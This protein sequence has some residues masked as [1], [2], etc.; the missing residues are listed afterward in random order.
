[1]GSFMKIR[2]GLNVLSNF[3]KPRAEL[4]R[5]DVTLENRGFVKEVLETNYGSPDPLSKCYSPLKVAP[6]EPSPEWVRGSRRT[7]TIARKLGIYPM[8]LKNGKKVLSTLLH[9]CDN[10]VIKYIPPEEWEPGHR[11][12][13]IIPK[14]KLGCL[15]VGAESSDPQLFTKEYCGLFY[16][17]G[18]MPKRLLSRFAVTPN[19][20]LQPGTPLLATHYRPG[21]VIDIRGKTIDRGF[22]GVM[23]RWG[24]HGMPA[25]HGVTKTHRR[26]GNIGSGGQKARVMPGQVCPGE[27]NSLVHV[28][29]TLLPRRQPETP[30]PFPTFIPTPDTEL[31][32]EAWADD[33]HPFDAP[34]IEFEPEK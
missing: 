19:G 16:N 11:T 3:L 4:Y 15:V 14:R 33:V 20:A 32:N 10:H 6:I 23:K 21:D 24:F 9:I 18:V 27:T 25:T 12:R 26:P 22:Q 34:T 2:S 8:W 1:M 31:P 17:A 29:D 28:Y 13:H 5:D 30:P 7:G